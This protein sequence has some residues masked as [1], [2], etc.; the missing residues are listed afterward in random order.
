MKNLWEELERR[1]GSAATITNALLEQMHALAAF[2]ESENDK[3]QVFADLC[4]DVDSQI[5]CLPGLAC[6]NF[7]NAIQPIAAR[8]PPSLRVN[9]E[10]EIAKYS[11]KNGDTYPGFHVFSNVIQKHARIKNNPNINMGAKLATSMIP[12]PSRGGQNRRALKTNADPNGANAPT[13]EGK[14]RQSNAHSTAEKGT[15]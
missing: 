15:A 8:L 1:F 6:L 12:T 3:L 2:R 7:P 5:S 11:E 13:K 14:K 9:W 4:A 10:K